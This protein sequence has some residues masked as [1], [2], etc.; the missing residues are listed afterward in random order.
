M[1]KASRKLKR[2]RRI[3]KNNHYTINRVLSPDEKMEIY[4]W[5]DENLT[6]CFVWV[7]NYTYEEF[8]M[9]FQEHSDMMAFILRWV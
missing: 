9:G 5:C 8:T 3:C 4:A 2:C 6:G 7:I 1:S